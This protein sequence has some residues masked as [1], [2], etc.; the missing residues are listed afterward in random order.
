MGHTA[1]L[2]MGADFVRGMAHG[3]PNAVL[4]ALKHPQ[5]S[6]PPFLEANYGKEAASHQT[7]NQSIYSILTNPCCKCM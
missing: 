3:A 7:T 2:V 5:H 4:S 1:G 6:L